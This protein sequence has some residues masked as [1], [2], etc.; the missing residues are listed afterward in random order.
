MFKRRSSRS[1]KQVKDSKTPSGRSSELLWRVVERALVYAEDLGA[2]ILGALA[3]ITLLGV[4][5]LTR[6]QL[7]DP[8]ADLL[9]RWL[10]WGVISVPLALAGGALALL[11]RRAGGLMPGIWPGVIALEL[12]LFGLLGLSSVLRGTSLPLAQQGA[13]GGLV[14]WGLATFLESLLGVWG[15]AIVLLMVAGAGIGYSLWLLLRRLSRWDRLAEFRDRVRPS[16]RHAERLD[17]APPVVPKEKPKRITSIDHLPKKYRKRFELPEPPEKGKTLA[18]QRDAQL[19]P[20]EMFDEDTW[21]RVSAKEIN[22]AA[23][24][25]E[26]TLG[27]FGLN[28]RVAGFQTGPTVTQFAVEPGYAQVESAGGKVRRQKVRVSQIAALA[29]DLALALAAPRLRIE[30]PVPGKGYVGIEVPNKRAALVHLRP[31]LSS[32]AFQSIDSPL[33]IAL[34]RDVSGAAV[35]ADLAELPHL[36]IAGTTGSGK[37]VCI[38]ALAS[39][40]AAN[41]TPQDMRLVLIDPKMVELVRFNGLPHLL[42]K[43]ESEIQRIVGVLR[44]CTVE[45]DRRFRLLEQ[46][47]ARDLD[48]YNRRVRRRK[49]VEQ[50]PRIVVM[51]D[52][53]AD[54][55][56]MMPEQ[57]EKT[58]VRLAQMSRATGIHLVV[59]T[60]RP[61]T[62]IVTGLIKA[63]FPARIAFAVASGVDSR[64]ILDAPGAES[65]LGRGDMLFMSPDA[66]API[67]LQGVFVKDLEIER[68]V[69]YWQQAVAGEGIQEAE[70]AAWEDLISRQ[71]ALADR[72]EVLER[73]IELVKSAGEA[74]ASMLQRRLRIGYPRAARLMDELEEMGLVGELQKGGRTRK[75]VLDDRHDRSGE[76]DD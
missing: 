56:M 50:L 53:L 31:M 9:R 64:V 72:D 69:N 34:G 24:L 22:L 17:S 7:V 1:R 60:Q 41:N 36:L 28:V 68:L 49:T 19:P 4:L 21:D 37:S 40:L 39:C 55:M 29:N 58:L 46:S 2:V 61:S 23:G 63:N 30:A 5:G 67:R 6:G 35:A 45:M 70:P 74:S 76:A 73:A 65:L 8:W 62:D 14:G 33:A 13:A 32:E 48:A 15:R 75:V 44:W 25:I 26:K 66:A 43:V 12:A 42:G 16:A 18:I 11:R 54:L 20:I 57:T 27:D 52:E 71:K 38:T 51:I 10:G 3:L 59:A 47:R